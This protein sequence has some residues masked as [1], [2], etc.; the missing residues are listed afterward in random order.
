M[1]WRS[2]RS[3]VA[4]AGGSLAG[5]AAAR[6]AGQAHQGSARTHSPAGRILSVSAG[7]D[8]TCAVKAD[9][10]LWCWGDNS[11]GGLGDGTYY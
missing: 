10:T 11:S 5:P 6:A 7:G 3:A 4:V 1:C 8:R 2:R 9:H